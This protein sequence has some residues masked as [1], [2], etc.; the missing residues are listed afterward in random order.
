[1]SNL[2]QV[3][4]PD[5]PPARGSLLAEISNAV[6][7]ATAD[8]TGRGPTRARTVISGDW[9]F[10]T[11]SDTLTKGERRL[12]ENG[13]ADFVRESRYAFQQV[14]R[15]DLIAEIERLTGRKVCAFMS[16]N[17]IDP[18]V[19]IEVFMLEPEAAENRSG[20]RPNNAH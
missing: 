14:M 3:P 16:D 9:V 10:V 11:L 15:G 19:A 2:R 6:V 1:M 18:D 13:R 20:S 12:A 5:E 4:Q 7:R 8:Y 17:H